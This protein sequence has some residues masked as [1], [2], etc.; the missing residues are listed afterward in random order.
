M[1]RVRT[2]VLM[3]GT[4]LAVELLLLRFGHD[5]PAAQTATR[6][7]GNSGSV[8]PTVMN[9][10]AI[11]IVQIIVI[12]LAGRLAGLLFRRFGQ[13]PVIGEIAA[14][15][16]LGPSVF[17]SLAPE[18]FT[19]L[20]PPQSIPALLS[21]SHV[22]LV[23]FMFLVG[24]EF[25]PDTMRER[26]EG[27]VV[28]SHISIIVPFVLGTA[29]AI[30]LYPRVSDSSVTF[31]SFAL[32][33]GTS[34]SVTAFPVL[35]RI[36][37][38]RHMLRTR[39]GNT[40]IACAAVDDV[41]AWCMLA[42][43]VMIARAGDPLHLFIR[44]GLL[45]VY[46]LFMIAVVRPLLKKAAPLVSRKALDETGLAAVLVLVLASSCITEL[47]GIHA[48]FGA[49]LVGTILPREGV[50][51]ESLRAHLRGLTCVIFLPLFFAITGL[52][53][54]IGLLH[55]GELWLCAALILAVAI[56]GK[57]GGAAISAV[58]VGLSWREATAIGVLMNTRGLMEM[59]VLNIGLDI[60]VISRGMFAMIVIM[61]LVTTAMTAPILERLVH[62]REV[63]AAPLD[64]E[65]VA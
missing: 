4:G 50:L 24:L 48:L 32:F 36:L 22:G 18:L 10:L 47:L 55:T 43:V 52:R 53:T 49:F 54:N 64:M 44:F 11:M 30:Y 7:A 9:E 26:S 13:P 2:Y 60:G 31:R 20:F 29:L 6:V 40:V 61:A 8:E 46:I 5:L 34:M 23:L 25:A 28:I 19:S 56:F 45:A 59:V 33:L 41:T 42:V 16:F 21:L 35:A 57:L 58:S 14:G 39:M 12:V 51:V 63:V 17:G 65:E 3:I 15:I 38:D 62:P 27:V 1:K 37:T